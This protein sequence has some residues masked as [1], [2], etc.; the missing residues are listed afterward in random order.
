VLRARILP[1]LLAVLLPFLGAAGL[2][3]LQWD[4]LLPLSTN[5]VLI[6]EVDAETPG[7]DTAEFVELYDG[8]IGLMS[9]DGLLVVFFNG[10]DDR[11][12]RAFDLAGY[13]TDEEGYFILGN[14]SA[15]GVDLPFADNV[16]QNGPDA[17]ALYLGQASDFPNGTAVTT[18]NLQDAL[19]YDSDDPD[20]PGLLV[21][22][23]LGEPQ[24]DENGRDLAEVHSNQRCPN[25]SGGWRQT[26][27]YSQDMP[28]PKSAN[29][30]PVVNDTAP[31]VSSIFPVAS[32]EGVVVNADISITFSEEVAVSGS[33]YRIVCSHSGVHSAAVSGNGIVFTL[34]PTSDFAYGENCTVTLVAELVS[35][36]DTHDPPDQMAEDFSWSFK[37]KTVP[38]ATHM[39]I[40]E[41]DADTPGSDTAEFVELFDGGE[42]QIQLD[43]LVIVL[44]NGYNDTSYRAID[45]D[46]FKTD[47]SGYFVA[48]NKAVAGVDLVLADG[49]IQNGA[50]A[51]AIYAA[52]SNDFP[53]GSPVTQNG[54]LDAL[55]YDTD[56]DD[57]DGLLVLLN[58]GQ[59]QIN[60]ADR[61]YKDFDSNQR[62]SNGEGG[63]RNSGGYLQNPATPG[64]GNECTVDTPP[65]VKSTTPANGE[66]DV[67]LDSD[68]SIR[69]SEDVQM[70]ADWFDIRCS[71]S[72]S[73][74]AAQLGG[75][76][77]FTLD[78]QDNFVTGELCTVTLFAKPIR[79]LDSLPQP[80][81]ADYSWTFGT[82]A[83]QFDACGDPATPIHI[84]QGNELSSRLVDT[85]AMIVEGVVTGDFQ[86]DDALD[87]FFLQ[88]EAAEQDS[89]AQTS[90]GIF[91]HDEGSWADIDTGEIVRVQ[92]NVAELE[93]LT[94]LTDLTGLRNCGSG[95]A[96]IAT[97]VS[98]PVP[99]AVAWEKVEG[100]L[101][102][103]PQDLAVT[104]NADLGSEGVVDLALNGRLFYPT[105]TT[106]P[107]A[108]ALALADLNSRSRIK[109]DDGSKQLFPTPLPPYLGTDK[110][111]RAG[112][113]LNGVR[114][115]LAETTGGYR[116]QPTESP[117]FIRIN[118]R[119][120]P[121]TSADGS[122]RA[123]VFDTGEYFN[124]DGQGSGFPGDRGAFT[125]EEFAR[126]RAKIISAILDLKAD[127]VGL[128]A[129]ENDGYGPDS[130][131]QDLVNGV[132][133]AAP[134]GTTYA[135]VD[136]AVSKLGSSEITVGLIFRQE[137]VIPVGT[138]VTTDNLPFDGSNDPP[139][140]QAFASAGSG[141]SFVLAITNFH[142]RDQ[143]PA[144]G[145]PNADQNDGQECWNGLRTTAAGTLVEF[146]QTDPTGVGDADIL[147]LGNLNSYTREDPLTL[148]D[149]AG[150]HSLTSHY[151]S[152]SYSAVTE[153]E[154][155][156]LSHALASHNLAVQINR[157]TQWHINADEPEAFGYRMDNQPQL[158]TPNIFRSSRQDPLLI[159]MMLMPSQQPGERAFLPIMHAL[160][161]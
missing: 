131:L 83:P 100:M 141:E 144:T 112:D 4:P 13:Q 8:G 67:P 12:Y 33:W 45:L 68:L 122:L 84:I 113:R 92:G 9:L 148:F 143:C 82:G 7:T 156:N 96:V 124:G 160:N 48:G 14:N 120:S 6:N 66:N 2:T 109:L 132:N 93:G 56:D 38:V 27:S 151:L 136:P 15:P 158:Y 54:L 117:V 85:Q 95:S 16:L 87:G 62:C 129:L 104:D 102:S 72:L 114:G 24:V 99:D 149:A 101:I 46:G 140:V 51:V 135:F 89:D 115:I 50:D 34:N 23:N 108:P 52:S 86:G 103:L 65:T 35:D 121:P 130:A 155:G 58:D 91:I 125:A 49:V 76:R 61:D 145:D 107:G 119:P 32:A 150:Y 69:F 159:D 26:E 161:P 123:A 19:V 70:D 142:E 11:S 147:I 105:E 138:A 37:V 17:V 116:I 1:R 71:Q 64:M 40:N 36:T 157:V 146:L 55:V 20:D 3:L 10:Q 111:L 60:E 77:Q 153:G 5:T 59:P 81:A 22:L 94:S 152:G 134:I 128:L 78:P 29:N 118:E 25:G 18:T 53:N 97:A 79:D 133:Q 39:L 127:V 63:Q 43:G 47:A 42:G 74:T 21:L 80:L 30:C 73:H 44:F 154:A 28:T 98:L 90:E 139:L 41:V 31:E 75:P 126:Q 57:D 88:E 110:T 106:E 137:T